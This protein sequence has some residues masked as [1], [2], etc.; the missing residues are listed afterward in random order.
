[1]TVEY[2]DIPGRLLSA[3]PM[4]AF[5]ENTKYHKVI[6]G[7]HSIEWLKKNLAYLNAFLNFSLRL[8]G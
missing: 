3:L 8:S 4:T 6:M 1:M 5:R 7:L 2:E